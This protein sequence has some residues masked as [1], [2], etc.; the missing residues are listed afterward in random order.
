MLSPSTRV[1]YLD[2][3]ALE[4]NRSRGEEAIELPIEDR[5]GRVILSRS[6]RL[7]VVRA[8]VGDRFLGLDQELPHA[9]TSHARRLIAMKLKSSSNTGTSVFS[10]PA[11]V[12]PR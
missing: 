4:A 2:A 5:L 6:V 1:R 11:E 10:E 8:V 3:G 12:K 7:E 9:F